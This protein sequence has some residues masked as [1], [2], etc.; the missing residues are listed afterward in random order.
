M[1]DDAAGPSTRHEVLATLGASLALCRMRNS[2]AG[3]TPY[4]LDVGPTEMSY[5]I[6]IEADEQARGVRID[7]FLEDN[8]RAAIACLY[9][10]YAESLPEGRELTRVREVA[11][12]LSTPLGLIDADRVASAAAASFE[13][14]DHRTLGAW[15]ARSRDEWVT[16]WRWQVDLTMGLAMRDDDVLALDSSALL[17]RQTHF[18][19]S[20]ETGGAF[21]NV[22]LVL[23]RFGDDGFTT[24]VEVFEPDQ[25]DQALSRFDALTGAGEGRAA[26][27]LPRANIAT[28]CVERWGVAIAARDSNAIGD[29]LDE[30][31]TVVHHATRATYGRR[32]MLATWRSIL[33]AE[34]LSFRSEILASL[35]DTLALDHYFISI[36]GLSEAHLKGFG[37]SEFDDIALFETDER[38]QLVRSEIFPAEQTQAAIERLH[39]R[40]AEL[41][42]AE[43]M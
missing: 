39:E 3:A 16:H 37:L 1:I 2:A 23:S 10:R 38:G 43:A 18:G 5:T 28:R 19:T 4:G 30:S 36:E 7:M 34:H 13:C 20:R 32:E 42:E 35:G 26:L 27:P 17:C 40:Y 31:L 15:S 8:L 21:E 29:M 24:R 9:E 14:V 6:V 11:R 25:E 22:V 12:S 33:K 41:C